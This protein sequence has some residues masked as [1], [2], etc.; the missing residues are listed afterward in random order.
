MTSL[1]FILHYLKSNDVIKQCFFIV[2]YYHNIIGTVIYY[3]RKIF[4][5]NLFCPIHKKIT[6]SF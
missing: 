5:L 1:K 4:S 3:N 6:D 2:P